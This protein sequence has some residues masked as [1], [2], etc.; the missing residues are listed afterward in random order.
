MICI[1][2]I[3][4]FF[5]VVFSL[6]A[7]CQPAGYDFVKEMEIESSRVAGSS[8]LIDFPMLV[9]IIDP[10]LRTVAN[11]G[12]VESSSGYDIVFTLSD[13]ST[14]LDHQIEKYVPSTGEY[15]AW[16][17]IPSLSNSV[18]TTIGMY[19][20]NSAIA[21]DP[22][23]T[24]TWNAQYIGVWHMSE[25]PA[26]SAPQV[27][28]YTNGSNNGTSAGGM[29]SG[30]LLAGKIGD[31]IDFDGSNDYIDLGDILID[32]RTQI[33]IEVWFN[34]TFIRTKGSPS[35]HNSSEGAIVHKNGASDDNLGITVATG[36]TAFYIDDNSNNTTIAALP[37]PSL[38]T[39]THIV[40]TWNNSTMITYQNGVSAATLG[41]V[42]GSF[43]NNSNSLSGRW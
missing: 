33:S 32:G 4:L 7:I 12:K 26:G 27:L 35:G 18:N 38:N 34:P 3:F 28:D 39:W 22:S 25:N 31:A 41:S 9:S 8:A 20:G 29:T 30:D 37:S 2:Y 10:D 17:R 6:T 21:S 43:V 16:L 14:L 15:V 40:G 23:T 24:S 13:C 1:K 5:P 36:G 19:Y 42:N 11:G